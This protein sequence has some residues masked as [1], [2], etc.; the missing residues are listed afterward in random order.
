MAFFDI[1]SIELANYQ[2]LSRQ[3]SHHPDA[4]LMFREDIVMS[5]CPSYP[6]RDANHACLLN[7]DQSQ[8][9]SLLTEMRSLYFSI[10]LPLVLC[11]SPV[12]QPEN[13]GELLM[14]RGFRKSDPEYW[15]GVNLEESQTFP[16][17]QPDVTVRKVRDSE[18][19]LTFCRIFLAGFGMPVDFAAVMAEMMEPVV[20]MDGVFYY[21]A[22][23]DGEDIGTN[24]L[25]LEGDY[26][27]I[28]S[29]TI[30]PD[31]RGG[32]AIVQLFLETY[33]DGLANDLKLMMT[34]TV[35]PK[36]H[37]MLTRFGFQELFSREIYE[38]A[39]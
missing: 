5:F 27:I 39:P 33:K 6:F 30:L 14:A 35:R 24:S 3:M 32:T 31:K 21:I 28:G 26:G 25:Y 23:V 13:L 2:A 18:D 19:L 38:Q 11:L 8:L 10:G 22:E 37:R 16:S 12:C 34:Q 1:K 17:D 36:V 29:S 4:Q 9:D 20:G 7:T 15:L